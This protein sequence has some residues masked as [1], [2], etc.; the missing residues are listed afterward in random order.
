MMYAIYKLYLGCHPENYGVFRGGVVESR[1]Q[2]LARKQ[3]DERLERVREVGSA[4]RPP[5]TG[6]VYALRKALGMT[7]ADLAQRMQV[8][9]QAVSNLE[10]REASGSATLNALEEA[11]HALGA[12]L[13]YAIV[14]QRRISEVLERRALELAARMTGSVRHSMKLEGQEP[15]S[16]LDARTRE[17]AKELLANPRRLWRDADA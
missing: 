13:V 9:R 17:L 2:E 12:E 16:A 4:L 1:V 3:L 8:S 10:K 11:A 5:R 14:P 7:Q 15:D 6:W